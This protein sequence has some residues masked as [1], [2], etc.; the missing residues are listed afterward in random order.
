M[1]PLSRI[2]GV[3]A[4]LILPATRPVLAAEGWEPAGPPGGEIAQLAVHPRN[5]Q[6]LWAGTFSFG[7]YKSVDGGASWRAVNRRL[8]QKTIRSLAVAPG[9]PDVLYVAAGDGPIRI[10]RSSNGGE[11]WTAVLPCGDQPPPCCGCVPIARLDELVVDPRH[12]QTVF[13]ATGRGLF[14]SVDGGAVWRSVTQ[15]FS[16][17]YAL[18]FDPRDADVLYAGA[19]E[20][21]FKSTNGGRSWRR[22]GGVADVTFSTLRIDPR[23]SRRMWAVGSFNVYRSTDGGAHWSLSRSGLAEFAY[24]TTVDLSP[25]TVWAGTTLG[26]YRSLDGGL[27][28][29][30]TLLNRPVTTIAVHPGQ[31]ATLWVGTAFNQLRFP[32]GIYKS[33]NRGGSWSFASRGIPLLEATSVVFDPAT[34]GA[35]WAT[36][37][38]GVFRSADGGATWADRSGDLPVFDGFFAQE[39]AAD[40]D[41]SRTLWAGTTRGVF[42]TE[43]GGVTWEP[44]RE[45]LTGGSAAFPSVRLLRL[46]PSDPSFAYA[47]TFNDLF[48]TAD[49]GAHWTKV[50]LPPPDLPN[51]FNV[52]DLLVD[53]RDPDVLFATRGSLWKSLDGGATWA[54]ALAGSGEQAVHKVAADPRDPGLL[55]AA[56]GAGV[57]RSA[58]GGQSWEQVRELRI[59][60]S[61]DIAVGPE[62]DV[63]AGG[64]DAGV[65]MSP[66]GTSGW[67]VLPGL[68][69]VILRLEADPHHPST[70]YAAASLFLAGKISG[71]LFR[72][73]GGLEGFQ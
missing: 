11:S 48:R 10:Y 4:L 23:D 26:L 69:P 72:H 57:F 35:L 31:A 51:T 9:N 66:D 3:F 42:V 15:A 68:D 53:P 70:V 46:A 21:L 28:W 37:H 12:P 44:R 7:I 38:G 47:V 55:Y 54:A 13:A 40:P 27:H 41:D 43:D 64:R 34:P 49:S 36:A 20:G 65:Y 52:E 45:G 33:V 5:P 30:P 58:D 56:G 73:V 25:G 71:G 17:T 14:K 22:W 16:S 29:K 62:G 60:G 39:L 2:L 63:W 19:V 67:T 1:N 59:T 6:V 18:A 32:G 24:A 61:G 50:P 8:D